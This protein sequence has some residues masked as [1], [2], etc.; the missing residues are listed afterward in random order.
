MATV[1]TGLPGLE[2]LSGEVLRPGD[3]GYDEARIVHNALIDKRPA[4]IVRPRTAEEVA[5]AV[6]LAR[7]AGVELSIKGGGHNVA[8]L[9]VSDGG[10]TIDM[11]EMTAVDIDPDARVVR[12]GGGLTWGGLNEATQA[13]GLAVT[14]GAISTTGI[15]GLTLGGGLGWLMSKHG[16]AADNLLSATVVTA[17]GRILTASAD[18]H[19][20]LFWAL[21]GGGGNFGVV[22]EFV[23]RLHPVG[24]TITGGLVAHMI[25]AAPD[26]LRFYRDFTS[27]GL[28][29]DLVAFAVL[30]HAPDGSGMPIAAF[31]VAHF[32][33]EEEAQ[34]DLAPLVGF[35]SPIMVQV[36]PMPYTALNAM[37]DEGFPKG[38]YNYWKSNFLRELPDAAIDT[39]VERF[40]SCPSPMSNLVLEHFH[41][42][43]S[44]RPADETPI[45][46][47]GPGYNFLVAGVWPDAAT[48]EENVAWTRASYDAMGPYFAEGRWLNYLNADEIAEGRLGQQFGPHHERLV[49]VKTAYDPGNLF[50]LNLNV[51]PRG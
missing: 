23:Y 51:K 21:R 50:R 24:P 27:A 10:V 17:D 37:L 16:L 14:G 38:V 35:G 2:K 4:V 47:R 13:H 28:S 30:A 43:V 49:D 26:L 33:S 1:G 12:A 40:A 42:E 32:G 36:G 39:M 6:N 15:A 19:P 46:V 41:G 8:G 25:D 34:R 20:D 29:D 18:E 7:E 31:A 9:A 48:T 22:T 45:V 3:A 44:R 11:S 5:E